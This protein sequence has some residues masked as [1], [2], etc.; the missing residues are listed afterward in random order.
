VR[1]KLEDLDTLLDIDSGSKGNDGANLLSA[2]GDSKEQEGT[3]NEAGNILDL[4]PSWVP[5]LNVDRN[6]FEMR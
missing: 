2:E 1:N 4:P 6:S 3:A 5:P